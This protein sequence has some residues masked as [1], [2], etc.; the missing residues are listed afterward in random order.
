[1]NRTKL[2]K[3]AIAGAGIMGSSIAQI[4]AQNDYQVTL[5]D[6]EDRFLA[7]SKELIALNQKALVQAGELSEEA[8]CN[9][10]SLIGHTLDISG[11]KDADF[12]IEAIVEQ[13]DA[14]HALWSKISELVSEEAI[15]TSNTSG[16][17]ISEIAK[18]VRKPERFCGMHWINPPHIV[19]LVEVICGEKTK[20]ET[21]DTVFRVAE[22]VGKKPIMVKKD[23]PGFALNRIQFAVLREAMH[24]V[25]SGIA[26]KED[27]DKVLK[28][29]LGMR[30]ACLGPF[31]VADLGGLDTFYR[32]AE[33]LFEDLSDAKEVPSMLKDLVTDGAW[34]VKSGKG[35]Y[36]YS[37]GR[38][39]EVISKR[40]ADFIK[41]A[42]ILYK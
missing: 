33:Y 21:A 25:E 29:G 28:Y 32:I 1:M 26:D 13:M 7:R 20:A 19:P 3:I 42:G 4:F 24:I 34:G 6:I 40:D 31:E 17:S 15:L 35:F 38:G 12:V 18:A 22:S 16:L 30:Y 41:I 8:S 10:R 9:I 36:D 39:D 11:F 27:V 5:Y 2:K 37:D 14:K 23:A